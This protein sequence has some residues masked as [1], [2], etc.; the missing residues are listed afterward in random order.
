MK[1]NS[2]PNQ[3]CRDVDFDTDLDREA[4]IIPFP[5]RP[6]TSEPKQDAN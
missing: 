1:N 5:E 4:T 6:K 3:Y 2:E